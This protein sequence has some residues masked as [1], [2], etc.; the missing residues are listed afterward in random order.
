[1][2]AAI[3][4]LATVVICTV[5]D[6][7]H[8]AA[9][10]TVQQ[11][12]AL[13]EAIRQRH[14]RVQPTIWGLATKNPVFVLPLPQT[15][16]ATLSRADQISLTLYVESLLPTARRNPDR[17]V[18][19]ERG[20]PDYTKFRSKVAAL[21]A[22]C[23]IVAVGP[24]AFD[25]K[26]VLA[27]KIAVAGDAAWESG[28]GYAQ[29][30]KASEF[31]RGLQATLAKKERD[32]KEEERLTPTIGSE[33]DAHAQL[34]TATFPEEQ[35]KVLLEEQQKVPL[36]SG[37]SPPVK[38]EMQRQSARAS[39]AQPVS[40][41]QRTRSPNSRS[42][43]KKS[44]RGKSLTSAG[45]EESVREKLA[46]KMGAEPTLR[47][48]IV[49]QQIERRGARQEEEAPQSATMRE[50]VREAQRQREDPSEAEAN[51]KTEEEHRERQDARKQLEQ[52]AVPFTEAAFVREARDGY[53]YMVALFLTA[54]MSPDVKDTEGKTALM[55]AATDGEPTLLQILLDGGADINVK[56][57]GGWTALMYA[58]WNGHTSTVQALLDRGAEINIENENSETALMMAAMNGNPPLLQIL[59][60]GGADIN[61]KD[62][63][64]W[65]A[66]MYAVWNGHTSTVQALLDRG[67]DINTKDWEG[68]TALMYAAWS[69][70]TDTVQALLDRGA[71][72]N[73]KNGE[74]DTALTTVASQGD[75]RIVKL[76]KRAGARD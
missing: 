14:P 74:N 63:G 62:Q 7:I 11:G 71:D 57:Q 6:F 28:P 33:P 44:G 54:G 12:E 43:E 2:K 35:E 51:H 45:R 39:Q 19:E 34:P 75:V 22:Q 3:L 24:L 17:Y 59:L 65:T 46:Q 52:I 8:D 4:F 40:P 55:M 20:Q 67:A 10:Q 37:S 64:G 53:P 70:H 30:V 16:W 38:P 42:V 69:G 32:L 1:M 49:K 60:D 73:A 72:V 47:K 9:G 21:C 29:G 58:V 76:L 41:A 31:R 15:E 48:E 25:G 66:L 50:S 56:D 27:E 18:G 13:F 36:V 26:G 68:W 23:W 61:V 5:C